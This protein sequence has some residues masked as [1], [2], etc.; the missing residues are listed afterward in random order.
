[1]KRRTLWIAAAALLVLSAG[2]YFE[3]PWWTLWRMAGAAEAHDVKTLSAYIDY[4]AVREDMRARINARIHE[5]GGLARRIGGTLEKAVM[6]AAIRPE[7]LRASFLISGITGEGKPLGPGDIWVLRDSFSQ[8]RMVRRDG[9]GKTLV[10]R[11]EWLWW[12]LVA[13]G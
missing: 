6:G 2:W 7:G 9:K 13:V 10:F 4:R 3:S 12:K 5:R 1:M 8:F 11:R